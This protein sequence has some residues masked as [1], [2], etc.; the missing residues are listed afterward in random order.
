MAAQ[1]GELNVRQVHSNGVLGGRGGV[2]TAADGR[3]RLQPRQ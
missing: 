2:F 3:P 1:K